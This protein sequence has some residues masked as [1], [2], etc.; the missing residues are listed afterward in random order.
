MSLLDKFDAVQI[1]SDSRISD[2]DKVFCQAHQAAYENAISLLY[3]LKF[4]WESMLDS[5]KQLLA[6]IGESRH[7]QYLTDG[8]NLSLSLP[9]IQ[10]QIRHGKAKV[11]KPVYTRRARGNTR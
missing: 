11:H 8:S 9:E 10:K 7:H 4:F 5:Q 1:Q 2:S 6:P 3:E